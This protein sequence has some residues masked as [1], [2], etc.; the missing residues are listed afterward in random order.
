MPEQPY[1]E[2]VLLVAGAHY[3][4]KSTQLRSMFLDRRLGL[5]GV[6][7]TASNLPNTF[8]LSPGRRLYLRLMSPHEAEEDLERFLDKIGEQ[9]YGSHRWNVAS[10]T[11]IHASEEMPALGEIVAALAEQ[12]SPERI[13][14]AIL[15]PDQHGDVLAEAP[16][17]MEEL[18][19]TESCEV[20]CIDARSPN[21]LLL[22]DTFDFG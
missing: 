13:R 7:P 2:R 22:A 12:Y 4:G 5:G 16:A 3:T 14:V 11:Q 20:M 8:E 10:A 19:E 9:A 18:H 17:L 6:I 21:G 15:S 1:I